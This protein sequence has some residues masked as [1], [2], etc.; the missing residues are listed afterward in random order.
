MDR[1][2]NV[3]RISRLGWKICIL[4]GSAALLARPAHAGETD[5]AVAA[6]FTDAAKAIARAFE[7]ATEH[8]AVLSFGSTGQLFTQITQGAPFEVFLAADEARPSR[9][10]AEGLAVAGSRFTYAI[11][12]LVLYSRD[13]T[14]VRGEDTL[15][16]ARFAKI[17]IANPKTAPH[18]GAAVEVMRALGV[19]PSL[20]D[21]IVQGTDIGQTYQ[22]VY[23]GN[24]ELGFV[25]L[26]QLFA[27]TEGSR[28]IVPAALHTPL[29]QDAA[30][31]AEGDTSD[32]ARAFM[33]YLRSSDARA[34]IERYGYGLAD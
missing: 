22:F 2:S 10:E 31:L 17:A 5:V 8:R 21:K 19:Y 13:A 1:R 16:E 20:L 23:T 30:L 12:Q 14:L 18:G 28:W 15:R 34:I 32:A 27:R 25:A 7:S 33:A 24:A 6:N 3:A 4:L 11:G 26:A 29:R 9:L